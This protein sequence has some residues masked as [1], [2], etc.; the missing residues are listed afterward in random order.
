MDSTVRKKGRVVLEG[1]FSWGVVHRGRTQVSA[2]LQEG[3]D[4]F[5]FIEDLLV[6][7]YAAGGYLSTAPG[8]VVMC[9]GTTDH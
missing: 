2:F 6:D 1:R 8:P 3:P 5:Q 7:R 4:A 9:R